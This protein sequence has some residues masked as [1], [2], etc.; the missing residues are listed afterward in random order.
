M[1]NLIV[2]AVL[3]LGTFSIQAR[4][5]EGQMI[6]PSF[7]CLNPMSGADVRLYI[8]EYQTCAN[9][10]IVELDRTVMGMNEGEAITEANISIVFTAA[11]TKIDAERRVDNL[12]FLMPKEVTMVMEGAVIDISVSETS[13]IDSNGNFYFPG[14]FSVKKSNG[15]VKNGKL[16]CSVEH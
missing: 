11:R 8:M 12:T 10:K 13:K 16:I 1:K 3:L 15:K 14:T 9:G 4:E 6:V 2:L 7:S 5:C